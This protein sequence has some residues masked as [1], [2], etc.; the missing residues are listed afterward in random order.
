MICKKPIKYLEEYLKTASSELHADTMIEYQK[1][2]KTWIS[3]PIPQ[4]DSNS[5]NYIVLKRSG[6]SWG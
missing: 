4:S 1:E 6:D 2:Y 3:K 5:S